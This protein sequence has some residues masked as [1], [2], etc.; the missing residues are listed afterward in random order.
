MPA[1]HFSEDPPQV[2]NQ[3]DLDLANEKLKASHSNDNSNSKNNNAAN[4][5]QDNING[6]NNAAATGS[7]SDSAENMNSPGGAH[8][9][10]VGTFDRYEIT[11]DDCYE[12]LGYSFP[13]WKKWYILT[14]IFWV[15]VSMNFNTSLYS[16]AIPGI[17]EEFHISD[18]AARC[19]AMIFLVLYAFGCELWAPWSEEFGRWPVL[20]LSLFL[21]NIWQ[22]PVALAPNFASIMVGRALGG[23]SSAGGSVTLGMIADLWEADVQQYAVAYVVFSS[24]GGSVLGPIVGGFTEQYLDWRWSIWVQLIL[25]GF[26][27]IVHFLTVPETRTTIMMNRIA[28]RRRK[29]NPG[30]NIWGPD[31]LVPFRDRFSAKEILNTWIRPFKMFLTEPIVLVLS[32]LSGFSDALIFMF[33]QSFSIVYKQWGF[34]TVEIGLS[35]IPIGI[36]YVIAWMLFIPAIKR[37]IKERAAKPNDERAQYESRLWFLLYTAPCLPIG[38]IGFAWTIQGPPLH[39]IG[40]MI[41][42]A[43]VGIANYAIYMA[44]IDYMIC[45]YGPYSASATGGNG[46]ARDFLAGVLTIPAVPFFTNIGASSGKNLEYASTI[47]FCI[48]FVLVVAVYII[49][50]KGPVLRHRSPFAQRLADARQTQLNEGRRGSIPY[51]PDER[52]AVIR[53]LLAQAPDSVDIHA[54]Y[55]NL[56]KVPKDFA[57]RPNFHALQGD[58]SDPATLDFTGSDAVLAITPPAFDGR[59]IVKHAEVVS[60]NVKD[61]IEAAGSVKRLV[62]LSSVGAQLGEGVGEIKTNNAAERVFATANVPSITFVRCAYFME[63]WTM[64]MDTLKAPEPFFFSTITPL[65]WKIPMVAVADIGSTLASELLKDEAPPDRPY[66]Y[67]L[68]GPRHYTPL[69][70]Q[71]AFSKAVGKQVAVKP[72]EKGELHGFYSQVFPPAIVDE[73]VEM[74]TSFLDGGAMA[75]DKVDYTKVNVV[76]GQ[77]ELDEALREASPARLQVAAPASTRGF[78]SPTAA[79]NSPNGDAVEPEPTSGALNPR[80]LGDLRSRIKQ[81]ISQSQREED[82]ALLREQ[83]ERLDKHW[84]DLLAGREGF[85]T[86]VR[87]RG[88]NKHSV[89]WG[90]MVGHVNNVIYN[91]YAESA[92]VNWIGSYASTAEPAERQQWGELMT[93]RSI[94][95]ILRSI[96]TDYKLPITYPDQVTVIHK[97]AVKPDYGADSV[98]LDAVILS[99]QHKRIAAR[100]FEDIAVYDYQA[101]KKAPLKDFMVDELRTVYDLQEKNKEA[102][103]RLAADIDQ[104]VGH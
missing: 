8:M 1:T 42:V 101:A 12:E 7:G 49:Y 31:E 36:G 16:N 44:T 25:G 72:V 104:A 62:L 100:C 9:E 38:L 34:G 76:R 15:Q 80:W 88:L 69:D 74:S 20:Q 46:W 89:A 68:H 61:A 11:E 35:F 17:T 39:W 24:V 81:K 59:D 90:D 94:G 53:C 82:S 29:E 99:E 21:V 13:K 85:L 19:G 91:R 10:K 96:K 41:F 30:A 50:W 87:W 95:L 83:L 51:H 3:Q 102:M 66:V 23:L 86:D 73:W 103:D 32:L 77:T 55:R 63:N 84:V 22:L 43:I 18:Q 40:S 26:V 71:A 33:I 98:I 47:L 45:A 2:I 28:K 4:A 14:V 64:G 70:V 97:L 57:E 52:R 75:A 67:E 6:V 78:V 58:I 54:L 92:R 48:S 79:R 93:P 27:Q 65:D 5:G 56:A 60:K 37:N